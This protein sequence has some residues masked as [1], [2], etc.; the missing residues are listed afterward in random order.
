MISFNRSTVQIIL[1]TVFAFLFSNRSFAWQSQ[2]EDIVLRGHLNILTINILY[3]ELVD[4]TERLKTIADFIIEETDA[5]EPV[6]VILLQETVSGTLAG[7]INNSLELRNLL[8]VRG[9][10]YNLRSRSVTGVR[11]IL[12][13]GNAL[14]S[15]CEITC[16]ESLILPFVP[17]TVAN[18]PFPIR[19]EVQMARIDVPGYNSI[20]VYNTHLCSFCPG[21]ERF[22]QAEAMMLFLSMVEDCG[23][24]GNPVI[25][26]G[27]FNTDLTVP[28]D[29]P[30]YEL[31]TQDFG[32][33][34]TYTAVHDCSDCCSEQQ[35]YAGCT[36]A[37]DD[38]PLAFGAPPMRIDYIFVK[39]T[40]F[41]SYESRV[42]FTASP[43]VSD[44]S[45]LLS[46]IK[47]H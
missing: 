41:E 30:V 20:D 35:G 9:L 21:S 38:N 23:G 26:G 18:I 3:S 47:L 28:T 5:S 37:V 40:A 29:I 32:F 46:R 43:W 33:T 4:R 6:D 15:R 36:Y 12:M 39:G 22:K 34:D 1:V 45:G 44:H 19:H 2:C 27:D 7:T 42:V 17:E 11:G 13:V 14:L 24:D 25:L 31:I 8:S 16:F 10:D